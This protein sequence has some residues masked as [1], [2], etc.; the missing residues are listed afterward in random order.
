[1]RRF[2]LFLGLGAAFLSCEQRPVV[3]F[4]PV[5]LVTSLLADTTVSAWS[6]LAAY[7]AEDSRGSIAVIGEPDRVSWMMGTLLL[8]DSFD[9]I[10][11]RLLSDGLPDFAGETLAAYRDSAFVPYDACLQEGREV[12]LREATVRMSLAALDTL[13]NRNVFDHENL[14]SKK[15]A[16]MLVLASPYLARYGAH[17]LKVLFDA[18][19][20]DI[21]VISVP[22]AMRAHLKR[23]HAYPCNVGV[24]ADRQMA[25]SGV[26]PEELDGCA[27]T[28]LSPAAE[29]PETELLRFL[30]MYRDA[31]NTLPLNALLVDERTVPSDSLRATVARI[32]RSDTEEL[33]PYGRLLAPDFE[34][35][36][37]IACTAGECYRVLRQRNL[38]T[39]DIA[40]PLAEFYEIRLAAG[41]PEDRL[42]LLRTQRSNS[43]YVQQ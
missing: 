37:A 12:Q 24:L 22:G 38:F 19:G 14:L 4:V 32:R 35:V 34:V 25:V 17:D 3:T 1:M 18:A 2:L 11:G 36:D 5:P 13:Y 15:R 27:V 16:K 33:M 26:F 21:P 23:A 39:H 30:D 9:N 40:Y 7:D 6:P 28:V 41:Q 8:Q 43:D 29:S 10:D 20:A 31:G 42:V